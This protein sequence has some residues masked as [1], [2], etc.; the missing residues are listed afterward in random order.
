MPATTQRMS[1]VDTAWLRMDTEANLM[2]IVGMWRLRPRI[3]LQALR[4]RIEQRLL[5]YR[6]FRQKVVED[7]LGASW[8]I[9]PDFDLA[10]HVRAETLKP[11]RGG[12]SKDT[13]P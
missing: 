4:E 6:R 10:R 13:K 11:R 3:T 8:V 12:E 7:P 9:D 2:L 5:K 1:R